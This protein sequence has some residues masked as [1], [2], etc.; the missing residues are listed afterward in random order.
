M[1]SR[2][3]NHYSETDPFCDHARRLAAARILG[4]SDAKNAFLEHL[5]QDA[6]ICEAARRSFLKQLQLKGIQGALFDLALEDSLCI[7][8]RAAFRRLEHL[9]LWDG[10]RSSLASWWGL[11]ATFEF[12]NDGRRQA[13]QTCGVWRRADGK[14]N[15][16]MM[17]LDAPKE[18]SEIVVPDESGDP[19][20]RWESQEENP[21]QNLQARLEGIVDARRLS[22]LL[23]WLKKEALDATQ[24]L[25]VSPEGIK[26]RWAYGA[27]ARLAALEGVSDRTLR[28]RAKQ[29]EAALSQVLH[30][31]PFR[32]E[33]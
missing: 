21:L 6:S 23:D 29:V 1:Q 11:Q 24:P 32:M 28:N 7:V 27:Q 5:L 12:N 9:L 4:T 14:T 26:L 31:P 17:S 18:D 16:H 8:L 13:E 15:L 20:M 25:V 10:K 2:V 33:A 3:P 19:A 22:W 30:A